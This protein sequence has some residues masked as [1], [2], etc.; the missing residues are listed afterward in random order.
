MDK[1][2]ITGYLFFL[3]SA[4]VGVIFLSSV[5]VIG[6]Q[7]KYL[8]RLAVSDEKKNINYFINFKTLPDTKIQFSKYFL[9]FPNLV[10]QNPKKGVFFFDT[11]DKRLKTKV[12]KLIL[13]MQKNDIE[14]EIYSNSK[15]ALQKWRIQKVKHDY[16]N[17]VHLIES[18]YICFMNKCFDDFI[19]FQLMMKQ[20][21]S[22]KKPVRK[23]HEGNDA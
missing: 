19:G 4:L 16:N 14:I 23:N 9:K 5:V 1:S 22:G 12:E 10:Y 6:E 17:E 15:V 13:E 21:I 20:E 8:N 18:P 3:L 7:T 11:K 2:K